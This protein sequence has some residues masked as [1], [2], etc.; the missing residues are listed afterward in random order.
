ML[1]CL[2]I[3]NIAVIEKTEAL[4]S[5]G[6][7][8]LTGQTGAGKTLLIDSLQMI[9]GE[10]VSKEVIRSGCDKAMVSALFSVKESYNAVSVFCDDNGIDFDGEIIVRRE[11]YT[12]GRSRAFINGNMVTLSALKQLGCLLV[13]IHGQH[14]NHA[15]MRSLSHCFFLDQYAKNDKELSA[16]KTAYNE[17][18]SVRSMLDKLK[19][20]TEKKEEAL[21]LLRYEIDEIESIAPEEGEEDALKSERKAL[22]NF[23]KIRSALENVCEI[24]AKDNGADD[25]TREIKKVLSGIA[26]FGTEYEELYNSAEMAYDAV[27]SLSV[28][29]RN[30]LGNLEYN[31]EN[32]DR[33]E[34][35]LDKISRLKRKYGYDVKDIIQYLE[36]AKKQLSQMESA[37]VEEA[38][39]CEKLL[40]KE[41]E[42]LLFGEA[43]TVT[44]QKA[45][46][47]LEKAITEQLESLDM[48]NAEFRVA[49]EP[50]APFENG[51]EHIE[52]LISANPGQDLRP[53]SK[54]A[55]GGELSRIMLSIKTVLA[56]CDSVETLVFDEIDS[57]VS[58]ATAEK[59]AKKMKEI[60]LDKQVI[61]VTHLA[62]IAA[63]ADEH[64]LIDKIN[65]GENTHT[66][67]KTITGEDRVR[68]IARII[69]GEKLVPSYMESARELIAGAKI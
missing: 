47:D 40:L 55:S 51:C 17:Y 62:Q 3:E 8:V 60:S 7:I 4:L 33:I 41:K 34:D 24:L 65:D 61:S 14:D 43:L 56:S 48:P 27:A 58:G 20:N 54:A 6:F 69:G 29:V 13:N 9:L 10:R 64:L 39:L 5:E 46:E 1:T 67:V 31:R 37:E 15:L 68:E 45:A 18:L 57:G 28:L 66:T 35:R 63:H 21:E 23:E 50:C 42:I 53:I 30:T 38:R 49:I 44:R 25:L 22:Q 2:Q 52:F 59:I 11:I 16:Y 12:D 26:S 36:N 19:K 32:L